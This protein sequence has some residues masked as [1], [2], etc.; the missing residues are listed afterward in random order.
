V[1]FAC[2]VD[3]G[4]YTACTSPVQLHDLADGDHSF[5]VRATDDFMEAAAN[6]G[7]WWTKAVA[8]GQP[9]NRYKA[10][11]LMR[12][13]ADSAWVCGD[14]GMQFDPTGAKRDDG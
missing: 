8:T 5:S 6:D 3:G 10:R 13:M 2:A 14:P 4:D 7:E 11:D 9:L 12:K 1:S